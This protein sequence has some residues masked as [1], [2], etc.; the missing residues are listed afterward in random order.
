MARPALI[1]QSTLH[2]LA[3]ETGG[4]T[5]TI[6]R[7]MAGGEVSPLAAYALK[8]AAVKLGL[9]HKCKPTRRR[10]KTKRK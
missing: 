4:S 8:A 1:D 7:W 6:R 5:R 2:K 9:A 3:L 10:I